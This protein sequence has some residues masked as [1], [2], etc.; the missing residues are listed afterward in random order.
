V[1][2]TQPAKKTSHGDW[3]P[4]QVVAALRMKGFSLRQLAKLNGYSNHNSISTVLRRPY[5]LAEALVAEALGLAAPEIWPSRYGTDG[6]PNR[7]PKGQ[8]TLLPPGAKP[9]KLRLVRNPQKAATA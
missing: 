1:S 5:P 2:A 7:G 9:S 3:H 6:K 8:Q 4:A